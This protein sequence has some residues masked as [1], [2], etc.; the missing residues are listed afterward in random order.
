MV[1]SSPMRQSPRRRGM[2]LRV[3][4]SADAAACGGESFE[5]E[6]KVRTWTEAQSERL[7]WKKWIANPVPVALPS[8]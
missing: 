7:S 6:M 8:V 3:R 2:W 1:I 4:A 5:E